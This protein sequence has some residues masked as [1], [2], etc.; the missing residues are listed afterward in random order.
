MEL[1]DE[2]LFKSKR[3]VMEYSN[4]GVVLKRHRFSLVHTK[5]ED[6]FLNSEWVMTVKHPFT[7]VGERLVL[8]TLLDPSTLIILDENSR[9]KI[10]KE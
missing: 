7:S 2:G 3:D 5:D 1:E 10:Q 4:L 8:V 9:Q 6:K